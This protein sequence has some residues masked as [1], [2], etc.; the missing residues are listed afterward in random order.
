METL[1]PEL[2]L[3]YIIP[4]FYESIFDAFSYKSLLMTSRYFYKVL[5]ENQVYIVKNYNKYNH[6]EYYIKH[7][8]KT[9][10]ELVLY[11][12]YF[13]FPYWL[14]KNIENFNTI[15]IF[16][17]K[18]DKKLD[19]SMPHSVI[20]G[21]ALFYPYISIKCW[22]ILEDNKYEPYSFSIFSN[23]NYTYRGDWLMNNDF[24]TIVSEIDKQNIITLLK[25]NTIVH[26][27]NYK[28]IM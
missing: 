1:P 21:M 28:L 23:G 27:N 16:N 20:K 8:F 15:P 5:S 24:I 2:I 18:N 7:D 14:S 11:Q 17:Q 25:K 22:R 9:I 4:Q 26:I 13:F 10:K 3:D 19:L 12:T 6:K